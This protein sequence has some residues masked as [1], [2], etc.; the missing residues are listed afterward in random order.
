MFKNLDRAN[1]AQSIE[2]SR[3][4]LQDEPHS[5][6]IGTRLSSA[7]RFSQKALSARR[8]PQLENIHT[9]LKISIDLAAKES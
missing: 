8:K 9:L 6:T 3:A 7:E 5:E 1:Q 4:H 2:I